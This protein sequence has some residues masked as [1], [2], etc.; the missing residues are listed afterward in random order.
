MKIR[1][2][3]VSNSSSS[4]FLVFGCEINLSDGYDCYA[5]FYE[6]IG[7]SR[8]D[9]DNNENDAWWK[10]VDGICDYKFPRGIKC[11]QGDDT[12]LVG[13]GE[14]GDAYAFND[15]SGA[16]IKEALGWREDFEQLMPEL[17]NKGSYGYGV[18]GTG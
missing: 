15:I 12:L 13:Y 14:V 16:V 9:I 8:E 18:I 4:S 6:R 2:G 7:I 11:I 1:N 10:I 17:A 5:A 3:F